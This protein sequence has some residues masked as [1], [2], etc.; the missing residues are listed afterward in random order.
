MVAVAPEGDLVAR[1][2]THLVAE[3]LGDH[4]LPLGTDLV[5]HTLKY[6]RLWNPSQGRWPAGQA[7]AVLAPLSELQLILYFQEQP[8]LRYAGWGGGPA[9][10]RC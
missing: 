7:T 1:L 5:S 8:N 2:Y 10:N 6:N 4:H 9:F 3:M